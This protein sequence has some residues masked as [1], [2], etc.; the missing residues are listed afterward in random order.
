MNN[1]AAF[2]SHYA[3]ATLVAIQTLLN[4]F[5]IFHAIP[6]AKEVADFWKDQCRI[7]RESYFKL[8]GDE[9]T[10]AIKRDYDGK[11]PGG[12]TGAN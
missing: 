2:I 3:F 7:W 4:L 1:H 11:D 5:F 6:E 8:L 9:T 10:K 12:K